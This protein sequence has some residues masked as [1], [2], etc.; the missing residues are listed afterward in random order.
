MPKLAEPKAPAVYSN[1]KPRETEYTISD[2]NG[3]YMVVT[4]DGS[5]LWD[6]RYRIGERR[7]KMAIKGGFPAVSVKAAR[8]EAKRLRDM[9]ARGEDPAEA[10]KAGYE[11]VARQVA[12]AELEA[13][14]N[15]TT[16]EKVAKDW[17]EVAGPQLSELNAI[18]TWRRIEKNIFP[19]IGSRPISELKPPQILVPLRVVAERGAKE[20]AQRLLGNC[21]QIFRFAV[22]SGVIESDP[23]RDLRGALPKPVERHFAAFTDPNDVA[24]LMRAISG[25]VGSVPTRVALRLAMLTFVR[26]GNLRMAEWDEFRFLDDPDRA[27][28]RISFEKMKKEKN[29]KATKRVFVV[30]LAPQVVALLDAVRPMTGHSKYLFPSE[31]S[32]DRPMSNN[33]V[34]TALRRMGFTK[35]EMTGHGARAMARTLCHEVLGFAPDVIEEQLA[36]EKAGPLGDAYDRTTHM[37][38]RRRLMK[39]W[40]NYL[41]RLE[42]GA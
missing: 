3:L 24:N 21:S 16:F 39:E 36:H 14:K 37:P 20:S 32:K 8:E 19:Y 38:E 17:F 30:P 27:E 2:G 28:W 4:P 18:N 42:G 33:T 10:R 40:A 23:T 35:E 1:A 9:V 5:K 29:K 15:A 34:N 41:D 13:A 31:L 25:Y 6:F 11:E 26:P 12:A 22:H 7:R